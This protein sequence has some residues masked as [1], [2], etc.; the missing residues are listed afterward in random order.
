MR[1]LTASQKIAVLESRVAKLEESLVINNIPLVLESLGVKKSGI[2]KIFGQV[3]PIEVLRAYKKYRGTKQFKMALKEV[4]GNA[5]GSLVNQL[6]YLVAK[7]KEEPESLNKRAFSKS[8]AYHLEL[9]VV[10]LVF[11]DIIIVVAALA[12]GLI[13]QALDKTFKIL[14]GVDFLTP[15]RNIIGKILNSIF[16]V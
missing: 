13:V 10:G 1:Q 15:T 16:E 4:K 9:L 3:Q 7:S 5:G 6:R 12:L 14:F 2:Q 11:G 8:G